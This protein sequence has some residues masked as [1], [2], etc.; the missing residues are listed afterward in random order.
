MSEAVQVKSAEPSKVFFVFPIVIFL[1]VCN[2][3]AVFAL[4]DKGPTNE[5]AV[6]FAGNTAF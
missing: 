4:P 6:T 2:L 5:V 3:V 1:A